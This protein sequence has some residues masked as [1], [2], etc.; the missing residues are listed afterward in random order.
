[1]APKHMLFALQ[2]FPTGGNGLKGMWQQKKHWQILESSFFT[3]EI[4]IIPFGN[5]VENQVAVDDH[6]NRLTFYV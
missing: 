4:Y 2:H 3:G 1:M 5:L 6:V